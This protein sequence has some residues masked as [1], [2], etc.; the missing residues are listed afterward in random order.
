MEDQR[1]ERIKLNTEIIKV[2][3]LLFIATGG[4]AISLILT[5]DVPIALERAYT[6]LSFAGML[7][8]I[9]AGI[10][11]IFVYVQTEKLLK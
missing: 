1:K 5:R 11:A 2:L 7:F 9:T 8:A 4:G 10:L 6:V 3:V